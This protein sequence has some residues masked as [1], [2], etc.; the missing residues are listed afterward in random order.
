MAVLLNHYGSADALSEAS[1]LSPASIR[2]V[3]RAVFIKGETSRKIQSDEYREAFREARDKMTAHNRR[4]IAK[5]RAGKFDSP[6]VRTAT[7]VIVP[8]RH[9]GSMRQKDYSGKIR[10]VPNKSYWTHYNVEHLPDD[11]IQDIIENLFDTFM[12]TGQYNTMRYEY[13][14]EADVYSGGRFDDRDLENAADVLRFIKLSTS[15]FVFA[16]HYDPHQFARWVM[17]DW[18]TR[19]WMGGVRITGL[20]FAHFDD[21]ARGDAMKYAKADYNKMK[22][23]GK[24]GKPKKGDGRG[25]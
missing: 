17:D 14:V 12:A 1:G 19:K 15:Q 10:D 4:A 25:V 16:E 22:K 23:R 13:I 8:K 9:Q 18:R 6:I 2:A 20:F 3:H 21:I 11:E 7:N 24:N 5:S